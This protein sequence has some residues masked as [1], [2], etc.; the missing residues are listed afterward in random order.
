MSTVN[1]FQR[2]LINTEGKFIEAKFQVELFDMLMTLGVTDKYAKTLVESSDWDAI[3]ES[4][5]FDESEKSLFGAKTRE[6]Q[7]ALDE[8]YSKS[9]YDMIK[10]PLPQDF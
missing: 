5:E 6:M 1:P 3:L 8:V 9:I 4:N 7:R 10:Q 2:R